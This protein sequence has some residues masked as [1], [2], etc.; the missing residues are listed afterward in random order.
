MN[1]VRVLAAKRSK[2]TLLLNAVRNLAANAVRNLAVNTVRKENYLKGGG[3]GATCV[4]SG[5]PIKFLKSKKRTI[6]KISEP[7]RGT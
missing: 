1:C 3:V 4:D 2:K 7:P 6:A 5:R